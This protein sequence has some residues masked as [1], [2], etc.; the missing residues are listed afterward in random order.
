MLQ[1]GLRCKQ[2]IIIVLS[3]LILHYFKA[4]AD[5]QRNPKEFSSEVRKSDL[6]VVFENEF[7]I[8]AIYL[9]LLP[10]NIVKVA[11]SPI[12]V[13]LVIADQNIVFSEPDLDFP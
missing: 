7:C 10:P 8:M 2:H 13:D 1:R 6:G 9:I 5:C 4:F 11:I 12:I 3:T